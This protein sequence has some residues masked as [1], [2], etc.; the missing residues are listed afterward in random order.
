MSRSRQGAWLTREMLFPVGSPERPWLMMARLGA[1]SWPVKAFRTRREAGFACF[2]LQRKT[3]RR[4]A[5][6]LNAMPD[7]ETPTYYIEKWSP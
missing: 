6:R 2:D 3:R 5:G 4:K 7:P 1:R